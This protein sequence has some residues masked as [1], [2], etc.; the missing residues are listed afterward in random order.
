MG[1]LSSV[2]LIIFGLIIVIDILG[3]L[4]PMLRY[5]QRFGYTMLVLTCVAALVYAYMAGW[6]STIIAALLVLCLAAYIYR[7]IK[8]LSDLD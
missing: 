3:M 4:I 5:N 2:A 1:D 6:L 8:N 7:L